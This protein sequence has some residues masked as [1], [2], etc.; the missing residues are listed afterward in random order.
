MRS[1]Y[2][3]YF[4]IRKN[5]TKE[6]QKFL[7]VSPEVGETINNFI[8]RLKKTVEHCE[9]G[10][11]EENQIRDRVMYFIRDK[12]LKRMLF[13]EESWYER[14]CQHRLCKAH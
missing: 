6:R 10:V 7:S 4:E 9:Y 3:K 11:E 8:I 12:V 2:N 13:R 1:M 5:V 14:K